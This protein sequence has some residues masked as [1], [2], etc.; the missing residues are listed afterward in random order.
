M[1]NV[2]RDKAGNHTIAAI[3]APE[4]KFGS[5]LIHTSASGKQLYA[6]AYMYLVRP[7]EWKGDFLYV[8]AVDAD[9]ARLQY[10]RSNDPDMLQ[11]RRVQIT[12]VAPVIGYFADD[13][14]GDNC[15]A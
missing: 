12:G 6:I 11:R 8:H 3:L 2:T 5:S 14:H 9:D 15:S 1:S 13:E 4:K 7:G 10:Y